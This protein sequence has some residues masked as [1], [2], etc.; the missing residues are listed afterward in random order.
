MQPVPNG[1]EE[2]GQCLWQQFV[3]QE[4]QT[5]EDVAR[6]EKKQTQS[7]SSSLS[8]LPSPSQGCRAQGPHAFAHPCGDWNSKTAPLTRAKCTSAL[9]LKKSQLTGRSG[10]SDNSQGKEGVIQ[11]SCVSQQGLN[12][13]PVESLHRDHQKAWCRNQLSERC[14]GCLSDQAGRR[15]RCSSALASALLL[16]STARLY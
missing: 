2:Q 9:V 14:C 7:A 4:L 11:F 3:T 12:Q 15:A 16:P 8:V 10:S 13:N 6:A 1:Q 5:L